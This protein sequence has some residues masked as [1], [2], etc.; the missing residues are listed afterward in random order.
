MYT[1][2]YNIYIYANYRSQEFLQSPPGTG[3]S[4]AFGGFDVF[5]SQWKIMEDPQVGES[6]LLWPLTRYGRQ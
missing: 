6:L 3:E 4:L 2:I 5:L 1:H